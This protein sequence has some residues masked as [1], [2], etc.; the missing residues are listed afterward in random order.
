MLLSNY[1]NFVRSF[2]LFYYGYVHP[3][4]NIFLRKD[5]F[6]SPIVSMIVNLMSEHHV[7]QTTL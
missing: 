3:N 1:N 5:C 6:M 7:I 4:V 2:H